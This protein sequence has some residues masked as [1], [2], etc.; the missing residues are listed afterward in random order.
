[1][2][3]L[4]ALATFPALVVGGMFMRFDFESFMI[5]GGVESADEGLAAILFVL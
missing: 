5:I 1:M 4:F 3:N 2:M